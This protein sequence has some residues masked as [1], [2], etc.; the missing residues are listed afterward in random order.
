MSLLQTTLQAEA[1]L[2]QLQLSRAE[3]HVRPAPVA[4]LHLDQG[5][6]RRIAAATE[7]YSCSDIKALCRE[8]ALLAVRYVVLLLHLQLM[9]EDKRTYGAMVRGPLRD[10]FSGCLSFPLLFDWN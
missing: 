2:H 10:Q 5:A 8:A 9:I 4:A 1:D 3:I 6:L 7:G